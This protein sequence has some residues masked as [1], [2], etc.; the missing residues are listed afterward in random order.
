MPSY[1]LCRDLQPDLDKSLQP[2]LSRPQDQAMHIIGRRM[3][4]N[5][6][7]KTP[8]IKKRRSMSDACLVMAQPFMECPVAAAALLPVQLVAAALSFPDGSDSM[9]HAF[10]PQVQLKRCGQPHR[11]VI[12]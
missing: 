1:C 9:R 7:G 10:P 6:F 5:S 8:G 4:V 2:A 11:L 12:Q 3:I